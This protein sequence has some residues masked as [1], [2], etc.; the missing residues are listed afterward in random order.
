[1][2]LGRADQALFN[3]ILISVM[4]IAYIILGSLITKWED[5]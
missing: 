1:M 3:T 2:I 5:Y 4:G